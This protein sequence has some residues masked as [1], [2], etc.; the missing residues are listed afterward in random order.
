MA[1][2]RGAQP[3]AGRGGDAAGPGL[4]GR[5]PVPGHDSED[6]GPK[7]RTDDSERMSFSVWWSPLNRTRVDAGS[8]LPLG[9]CVSRA[10]S[11]D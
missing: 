10:Y 5:H 6:S 2:W 3:R 11:D 7:D 4:G 9:P 8:P 1:A